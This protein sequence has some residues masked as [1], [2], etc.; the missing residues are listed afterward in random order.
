M[1]LSVILKAA[2]A[3][4]IV[5]VICQILSRSGRD[6]QA[7]L[8]SVAGMIIVL[9]LILNQVSELLNTVKRIFGL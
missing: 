8:V 7:M 3:G 4:L 2:G 5:S 1:E 9:T 6:E